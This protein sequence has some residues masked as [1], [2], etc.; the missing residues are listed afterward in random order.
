MPRRRIFNTTEQKAIDTAPLFSALERKKYFFV[1][2]QLQ[3]LIDSLRNSTNQVCFLIQLGYF[4]ATNRFFTNQFHSQDVDYVTLQL[5]IEAKSADLSLYKESTARRHRQLILEY[6]GYQPFDELSRQQ[7]AD[8]LLPMI[9]SQLRPKLLYWE[10]VRFLSEYHTEIPSSGVLSQVVLSF[11][12][13]HQQQLIAQVEQTLSSSNQQVLD[14]LLEL[15]RNSDSSEMKRLQRV[16]LTLLKR[17]SHSTKTSKIK[18]NLEDLVTIRGLFHRLQPT[19]QALDLT[20]DGLRYYA[21]SVI[22]SEIFQIS[23]RKDPDRHLHLLCFVAHQYF[24]LHDLL[25]DTLLKVVQVAQNTC[26]REHR[27]LYY[28][29][30][31]QHKRLTQQVL[32]TVEQDFHAPL[33]RIKHI[34]FEQQLSDAEKIQY[35]Q[36]LFHQRQTSLDDQLQQIKMDLQVN[37]ADSTYYDL[38]EKRSIRLQNRVNGILQQIDF[39]GTTDDLLQALQHYRNKQGMIT[40]NA[41]TDFLDSMEKQY[42]INKRGKFRVSLYKVL[43]ASKVAEAIKSGVLSVATSYRYRSLTQYLIPE[44]EWKQNRSTYLKQADLMR[45]AD[46]NT[47]LSEHSQALHQQYKLTNSNILQGQNEHITLQKDGQFQLKTPQQP[48][49][50]AQMLNTF[51][52]QNRYISLIEVLSTIQK[53]SQFL[54]SFQHWQVKHTQSDPSARTFFAGIIGYGCQVGIGKV[55]RISRQIS[56][57]ELEHTVNW[58]FSPD[59]LSDANDKILHLTNQLHLPQLYQYQPDILHTSS[60]GQKV[61]TLKDSPQT[62]YSFK[63]FGQRQGVST[64]T[65]IDERHLL[66]YSTVISSPQK[67][68]AYVIDGLL[69][70]EVVKSNLHSTDTGGYTEILFGVMHLLGFSYAP[71]IKNLHRQQRYSFERRKTY[72]QLQYPVLPDGYINTQL[73]HEQWDEILRFVATIKLKVTSASQ[74][75]HRLNSY[76][77]QHPLYRALK[78]L[79]KIHKSLFILKWIDLLPLR[80]RVEKQ[81]NKGE[82]A[83][84]FANA[85]SFSRNQE[86]LYVEHTEQEIAYACNRL[87]RN[88]IICWNYLYLSQLLAQES[89]PDRRQTLLDSVKNG[90]IMIWHHLNLHGEYDFSDDKLKDS[91]GFDLDTILDLNS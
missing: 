78:E 45:Y 57:S 15:D 87:I 39:Q 54:D 44:Q 47:F 31:K 3:Q 84:R 21:H 69:H 52:P 4:R 24:L 13:T 50:E 63:Y 16:K 11:V 19:I 51:F 59:N 1:S 89:D 71:R 83:N 25:L 72:Q 49:V 41:P 46:I 38:L 77:R 82:Q 26:Q 30:R 85:V 62:H 12:N 58:Y 88:A 73:L 7:L 22:R 29:Q 33:A 14:Q 6:V 67:E 32:E 28:E 53:H 10:A 43:L 42:L 74:L 40:A 65:F 48:E 18:M 23:R 37:H 35:I 86:F 61:L 90:S 80:Q 17:F 76:S 2:N 34:A 81:L 5:G 9:R 68:A 20:P 55:A 79:G 60:D 8:H 27:N 66:F 64:Y 70:N 36:Q 56:A 91:V 75:F